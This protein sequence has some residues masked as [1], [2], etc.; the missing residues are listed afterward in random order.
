M[1][2]QKTTGILCAVLLVAMLVTIPLSDHAFA[3]KT[4]SKKTSNTST[5]GHKSKDS[6]EKRNAKTESRH[7]NLRKNVMQ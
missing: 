2:Q 1:I 3:A 4:T 7:K 6:I 5:I